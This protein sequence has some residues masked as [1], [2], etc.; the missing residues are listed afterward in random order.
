MPLVVSESYKSTADL[1]FF[2]RFV[3]E[4]AVE[5]AMLFSQAP[6]DLSGNVAVGCVYKEV[7]DEY[8]GGTDGE[9]VE[10]CHPAPPGRYFGVAGC[11]GLVRAG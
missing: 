7:D 9:D 4:E 1:R 10:R 3:G 8:S 11:G 5:A 2:S 6:I